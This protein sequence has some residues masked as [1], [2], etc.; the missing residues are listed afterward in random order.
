MDIVFKPTVWGQISNPAKSLIKEI[1]VKEDTRIHFDQI[2]THPWFIS[3]Y[4]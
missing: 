2:L 3:F 4:N 1:L